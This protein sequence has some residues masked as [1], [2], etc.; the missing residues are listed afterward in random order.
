MNIIK[1]GYG[2]TYTVTCPHCGSE[3][4]A[5]DGEINIRPYYNDAWFKCPACDEERCHVSL[6]RVTKWVKLSADGKTRERCLA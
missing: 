3:L 5:E 2:Y 1:R 6:L 4:E